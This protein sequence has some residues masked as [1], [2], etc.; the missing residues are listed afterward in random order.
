MKLSSWASSETWASERGT[1]N[2]FF[3][4][5]SKCIVDVVMV[6]PADG[7][8]VVIVA[9]AVAGVILPDVTTVIGAKIHV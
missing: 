2:R 3:T 7:V 6:V 9:D 5:L 8:V 1:T 4:H